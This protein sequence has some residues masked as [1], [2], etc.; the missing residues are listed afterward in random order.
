M[1]THTPTR[2]HERSQIHMFI[3]TVMFYFSP[4]DCQRRQLSD[5]SSRQRTLWQGSYSHVLSFQ[6]GCQKEVSCQTT[7]PGRE[8]CMWKG[9][10]SQVLPSHSDCQKGGLS[11]YSSWQRALSVMGTT[12]KGHCDQWNGNLPEV[13]FWV[14][15]HVESFVSERS[16]MEITLTGVH[17]ACNTISNVSRMVHTRVKREVT[18]LKETRLWSNNMPAIFKLWKQ[19]QKQAGAKAT[20]AN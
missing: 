17:F 9:P 11:D 5:F 20:S 7:A 2:T 10:Y 1:H 13:G 14:L 12:W 6:S 16:Y 19:A 15:L 3:T 4:S 18:F 8:L